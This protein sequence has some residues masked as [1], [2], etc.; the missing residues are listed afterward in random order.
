MSISEVSVRWTGHLFA[1]SSNLERCSVVKAQSNEC[2]AQSSRAA[3][4]LSRSRYS[5]T[6]V[7]SSA[8]ATARRNCN[9]GWARAGALTLPLPGQ[10]GQRRAVCTGRKCRSFISRRI[11]S[12]PQFFPSR[13]SISRIR[14]PPISSPALSKDSQ[15]MITL[16]N[17]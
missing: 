14:A 12:F 7:V 17:P 2:P 13:R 9:G 10:A 4:L 15:G 5:R 8:E 11:R 3:L 16:P 1:I 6:R